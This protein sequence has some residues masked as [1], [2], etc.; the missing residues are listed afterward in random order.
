LRHR[1][2]RLDQEEDIDNDI[3]ND[4]EDFGID[5]D[6]FNIDSEGNEGVDPDTQE[7]TNPPSS[8][9]SAIPTQLV[10]PTNALPTAGQDVETAQQAAQDAQ[11]AATEAKN[12]AQTE[13]E[14]KAA[15]AAQAAA[16]AA[17]TAADATSNA[18]TQAAMDGLLSGDGTMMSSIVTSCFTNPAYGIASLDENGTVNTEAYIYLDGSRYYKLILTN[19]YFEV[20]KVNRPL[21]KAVTFSE[22]GSGGDFVDWLLFFVLL[23]TLVFAVLVIFQQMGNMYIES[24]YKCQRWFFNPRKYDYEGDTIVENG[25]FEFGAD[26]IPLSMGGRRTHH[27][28]IPGY[29]RPTRSIPED[30]N[31]RLPLPTLSHNGSTPRPVLQKPRESDGFGEVE[32]SKMPKRLV[33]TKSDASRGT[34]S[35]DETSIEDTGVP[36]RLIRDPDLVEFPDLKSRSKVAVPV[37]SSSKPYK[38]KAPP[39]EYDNTS[40]GSL[41]D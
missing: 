8:L 15:N 3:D 37:G 36:E 22:Y 16:D 35:D 7:P 28:P 40:M 24:L 34:L 21:P 39:L 33:R 32:L 10:P 25:L 23:G 11:I 18:A 27:S 14:T 31:V 4:D 38:K 12:A 41:L 9:E 6:D 5:D 26:G 2:R 30:E 19:P 13:G 1:K 17:Q 29:G 20:V